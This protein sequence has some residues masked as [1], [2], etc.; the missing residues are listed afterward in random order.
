MSRSSGT[1]AFFDTKKRFGKITPAEG[2]DLV[3][4]HHSAVLS[5][6]DFPLVASEPVEYEVIT[7]EKGLAAKDVQR[8]ETRISGIVDYFDRQKGW[9][10]I[11]P[12]GGG[13]EVFVHY[14]EIVTH[15]E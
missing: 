12:D 7:T 13:A 14:S 6:R 8:L 15:K 10:V 5:Q 9:G 2:G 1:V 11:L 4:V 3:F